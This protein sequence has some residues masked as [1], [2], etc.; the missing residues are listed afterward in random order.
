MRRKNCAVK[1]KTHIELINHALANKIEPIEIFDRNTH[2]IIIH[3]DRDPSPP[4]VDGFIITDEVCA[5][6]KDQIIYSNETDSWFNHGIIG[7]RGEIYI[8]IA[9]N[10]TV[11]L[12]KHDYGNCYRVKLEQR[13]K[14]LEQEYKAYVD[15]KVYAVTKFW[16]CPEDQIIRTDSVPALFSLLDA[17]HTVRNTFPVEINRFTLRIINAGVQVKPDNIIIDGNTAF[18]INK[19]IEQNNVIAEASFYNNEPIEELHRHEHDDDNII[20]TDVDYPINYQTSR[21]RP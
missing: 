12:Y 15:G 2:I 16:F 21:S 11:D 7:Y 8:I 6:N 14:T 13:M 10:S 3:K 19:I 9:E 17:T 1:T 20:K 5:L 4:E 18:K